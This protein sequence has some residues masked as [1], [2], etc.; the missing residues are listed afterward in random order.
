MDDEE[1]VNERP[2]SPSEE[3]AMSQDKTDEVVDEAKSEEFKRWK[4]K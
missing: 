4:L 1:S 3:E 2:L